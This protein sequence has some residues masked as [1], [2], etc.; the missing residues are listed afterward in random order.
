MIN[1]QVCLYIFLDYIADY[2]DDIADYN[3]DYIFNVN[4]CAINY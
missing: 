4:K 1:K 3:V 2:I